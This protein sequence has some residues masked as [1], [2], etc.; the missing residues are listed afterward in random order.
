[1]EAIS[2]TYIASEWGFVAFFVNNVRLL[3]MVVDA[4]REV[5]FLIQGFKMRVYQH[6]RVVFSRKCLSF[7]QIY[8][9][10]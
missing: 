4:A 3:K 5:L 2:S 9:M 8:P 6:C 10:K 7:F 1:M